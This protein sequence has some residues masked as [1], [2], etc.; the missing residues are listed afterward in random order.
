MAA[1]K[2]VKRA[3]KMDSARNFVKTKVPRVMVSGLLWWKVGS[4]EERV[5]WPCSVPGFVFV[6]DGG[7]N[8]CPFVIQL[9]PF[10]PRV[11][12]QLGL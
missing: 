4:A 3:A 12:G 9:S 6:P 5:S 11:S 7:G 10:Y 8:S 2:G 1:L